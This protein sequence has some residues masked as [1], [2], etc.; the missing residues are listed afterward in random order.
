MS[1]STTLLVWI[2]GTMVTSQPRNRDRAA[3]AH[4][5]DVLEALPLEPQRELVDGDDRARPVARDTA[6]D[7]A[8]VIR[9]AVGDQD[10]IG[11]GD[12]LHVWRT[13]RVLLETRIGHDPL[14]ARRRDHERRMPVPGDGESSCIAMHDYSEL[15]RG[16]RS[17]TCHLAAAAESPSVSL[18]GIIELACRPS[19]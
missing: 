15:R 10:H 13:H 2:A 8:R 17:L 9:V 14:A 18:S 12:P 4:A 1:F 7:V 5:L 16:Y 6:D 3:D 11:R 19:R